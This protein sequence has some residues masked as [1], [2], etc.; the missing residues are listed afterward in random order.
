M[1]LV[2]DVEEDVRLAAV[3]LGEVCPQGRRAAGIRLGEP[4]VARVV[5]V[6]LQHDVHPRLRAAL[7]IAAMPARYCGASAYVV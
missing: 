1:R 4:Q 3:G 6:K 5:A 2:P 7:M